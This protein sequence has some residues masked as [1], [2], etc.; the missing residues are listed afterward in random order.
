MDTTNESTL[1]LYPNPFTT[2]FNLKGFKPGEI[3]RIRIFDI[4]GKQVE[5]IQGLSNLNEVSIGASLKPGS[6][7]VQVDGLNSSKS[8]KVVK[9]N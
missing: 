2:N 6:Y 9:L 4:V 3:L 7:I 1:E 8:F 5:T